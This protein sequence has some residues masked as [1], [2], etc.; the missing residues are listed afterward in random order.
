VDP[1]IAG[2]NTSG[3][4]P[5][6][7]GGD[8][9]LIDGTAHDNTVG[10]YQLSVIPEN[11]FSGN[12]GYGVA[13]GGQ[14]YD[15]TVYNSYVGVNVLGETA[16]GNG[17][18]GILVDGEATGNVIGGVTSTPQYPVADVV[19]A[20][21]GDGITLTSGTSATSILNNI[22]GYGAQGVAPLPNSGEPLVTNGS[23]GNTIEGNQIISC[24]AAGTPIR[25]GRT[26]SGRSWRA[27]SITRRPIQRMGW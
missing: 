6:A 1:D 22:I 18:G 3:Q 17:T 20:N 10:G 7:N 23:T 5:L 21:D 15:N 16:E 13:I 11:V 27:Q 9:L 24:F 12:D 2:M 14:A 25:T 8:G 19:S 26:L 4:T